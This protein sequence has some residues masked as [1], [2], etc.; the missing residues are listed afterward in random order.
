MVINPI[1]CF[2]WKHH[3]NYYVAKLDLKVNIGVSKI[4]YFFVFLQKKL[5]CKVDFPIFA[6]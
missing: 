2:L 5:N 4:T 3:S 6:P 1:Y